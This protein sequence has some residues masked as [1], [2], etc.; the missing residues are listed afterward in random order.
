M[1][2]DCARFPEDWAD[3]ARSRGWV[4]GYVALNPLFSDAHGFAREDMHV[5]NRLYV[6]DL[7]GSERDLLDGLS[8]NRRRQLRNWSS[9]ATDTRA[10]PAAPHGFPAW[11]PTRTS[12]PERAQAAP[13]TSQPRQWLRSPRWTTCS[14]SGPGRTTSSSRSRSSATRRTVATPCSA[15]RRQAASGTQFTSYGRGWNTC[16]QRA[17]SGSTSAA[18]CGR[19]TTLRSS[20]AASAPPSCRSS[21]L[22]QVYRPDA[23][24]ELCR[25]AGVTSDR[26]GWFPPYR[27]SAPGRA[28]SSDGRHA[29]RPS[30]A[31]HGR[32][33]AGP[34]GCARGPA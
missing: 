1:S 11:R 3:F 15:S 2:G 14:W 5:H 33:D 23:Y 16:A 10:R 12:S 31:A 26:S 18:A 34:A 22:R 19:G 8:R 32:R 30:E 21:S 24:A 6:M 29:D 25:A 17:S 7:G 4:C 27:S 20:S 28:S 9:V 13:P